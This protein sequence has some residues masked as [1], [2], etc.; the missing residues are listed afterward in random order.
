MNIC[1]STKFHIL[2]VLATE[3]MKLHSC[4]YS[5][6][7]HHPH[8]TTILQR[9]PIYTYYYS[10]ASAGL[11]CVSGPQ[12]ASQ[13]AC[14]PQISAERGQ[15]DQRCP[16]PKSSNQE[17]FQFSLIKSNKYCIFCPTPNFS[18]S[19]FRC[20]SC[21]CSSLCWFAPSELKSSPSQLGSTPPRVSAMSVGSLESQIMCV[22]RD[23]SPTAI[24][25]NW[26]QCRQG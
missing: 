22:S 16:Q 11:T 18:A 3:A 21:S 13:P 12:P 14:V 15:S 9:P 25:V 23:S 6:H 2:Q 26:A 1:D 17:R 4:K 20:E 19:T 7:M 8:Q 24:Q 10:A 5:A